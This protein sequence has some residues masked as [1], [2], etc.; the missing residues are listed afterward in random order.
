MPIHNIRGPRHNE[1]CIRDLLSDQSECLDNDIA[2]LITVHPCRMKNDFPAQQHGVQH[3]RFF[4]PCVKEGST[5]NPV[6]NGCYVLGR[7]TAPDEGVFNESTYSDDVI[8][9]HTSRQS[10]E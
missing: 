3:V 5:I 7:L 10:N 6:M 4:G 9:L 8:P 2:P 1:K